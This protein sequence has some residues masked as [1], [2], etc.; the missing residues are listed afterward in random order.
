MDKVTEVWRDIPGYQGVYQIS[1]LGRV[2]SLSRE[3]TYEPT[4]FYPNGRVRVL[5]EKILTPCK[6]KKGY[7]FVQLF[8]NGFFKCKRIHRLVAEAFIP[9]PDNLPL[10]NHKDCIRNNNTVDNLEWCTDEYNCNYGG[11]VEKRISQIRRPVL[12]YTLNGE[13]IKEWESATAFVA[14]LGIKQ[15]NGTNILKACKGIYKQAFG[16]KWKLKE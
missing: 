2:K 1:N 12:Q 16:Y 9:N 13:F 5:K 14:T 10:V 6:D 3:I 11:A 8:K 4:K 15:G 7:E